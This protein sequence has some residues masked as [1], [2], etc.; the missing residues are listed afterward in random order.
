MLSPRYSVGD[1]VKV[2]RII[3]CAYMSQDG[4]DD[5][6]EAG[7][8]KLEAYIGRVFTI[9]KVEWDS[10]KQIASYEMDTRENT[11]SFYDEELTYA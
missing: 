10:D 2:V 1:K 5:L 7:Q 8:A 9:G 3:P 6:S 4:N 11:D